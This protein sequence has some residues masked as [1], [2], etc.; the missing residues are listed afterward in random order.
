MRSTGGS[1]DIRTLFA[2][3]ESA[4]LSDSDRRR[5]CWNRKPLRT[6]RTGKLL[7]AK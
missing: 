3:E 6:E 1:N 2:R 5:L 7:D 4:V